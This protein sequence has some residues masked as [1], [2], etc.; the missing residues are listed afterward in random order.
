LDIKA[1]GRFAQVQRVLGLS[2]LK[3]S[4]KM[5]CLRAY[6]LPVLLFGSKSSRFKLGSEGLNFAGCLVGGIWP[7]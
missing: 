5:Q 2:K 3:L 1:K 6:V 4:L 7:Q